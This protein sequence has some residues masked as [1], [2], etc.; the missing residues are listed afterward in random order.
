MNVRKVDDAGNLWFLLANDSHTYRELSINPKVNLFFQGSPHSDFLHLTG[1]ASLSRDPALID[2]L[3]EPVLK[4]WFTSGKDD[5]RISVV[6][7][8]P[9]DGYY[10]DNKHGDAIAGIKMMVGAVTGK[11]LDDS[12]EGKL[13]IAPG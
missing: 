6:K 7:V 2:E 1:Q 3:W 12:I 13:Y 4:T 11:T 8:R 10:W 5:P 9:G